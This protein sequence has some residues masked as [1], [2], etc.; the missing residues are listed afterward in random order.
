[1]PKGDGGE[2]PRRALK[3]DGKE[4]RGPHRD[5]RQDDWNKLQSSGEPP[6]TS[7]P[8]RTSLHFPYAQSWA[9]GPQSYAPPR[10]LEMS[11]TCSSSDGQL[12]TSSYSPVRD[13]LPPLNTD[14]TPLCS[15]QSVLGEDHPPSFPGSLTL[16][17]E[18]L[19]PTTSNFAAGSPAN[20]KCSCRFCYCCHH[21]CG[22][23]VTCPHI[24]SRLA[25]L[26]TE[27]W[28]P[29]R[30]L[31]QSKKTLED[32]TEVMAYCSTTQPVP[33]FSPSG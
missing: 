21:C 17:K 29:W 31:C 4:R 11:P 12:V 16:G 13:V 32:K 27:T 5:H 2:S 10:Q 20:A 22:I 14:P 25:L 9:S 6:L 26:L 33:S 3:T 24:L 1:M 8:L 30:T 19:L 23:K 28:A 18:M 7:R 15:P